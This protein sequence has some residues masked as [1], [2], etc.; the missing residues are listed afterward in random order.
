MPKSGKHNFLRGRRV[1]ITRSRKQSQSFADKL[2]KK[3]AIPI[4]CPCIQIHEIEDRG[5]IRKVFEKLDY[6]NIL[7]FS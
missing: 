7:I 5:Q 6:Y 3:G 4:I 1:L 2:K